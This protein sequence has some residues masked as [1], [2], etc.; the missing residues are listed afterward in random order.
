MLTLLPSMSDLEKP[1]IVFG[2]GINGD[3]DPP[4]IDRDDGVDSIVQDRRQL[5][6]VYWI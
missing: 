1:N 4:F 5:F 2:A 6:L 3:H